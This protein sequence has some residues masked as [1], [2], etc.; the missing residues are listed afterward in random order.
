MRIP[1]MEKV[2]LPKLSYKICGFCYQIHNDL[3]R[4]RNEKQYADAMEQ[5]LKENNIKYAREEFLSPSFE[6]EGNRNKPD[7][8]IED[9]IIIDFKAKNFITKDDYFQMKR[10]LASKN[11]K[12][13]LIINFHQKFLAPKRVLNSEINLER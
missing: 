11:I 1:Q 12:L 8:T 13:G 6:G 2:I 4:F 9:K 3:G 10:Y 5:L 7:F